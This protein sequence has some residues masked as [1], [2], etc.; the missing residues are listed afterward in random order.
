MKK[1]QKSIKNN[2]SKY[3][4]ELEKKEKRKTPNLADMS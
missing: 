3:Q 4:A 1:F 2:R